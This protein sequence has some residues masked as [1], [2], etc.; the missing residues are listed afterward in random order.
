MPEARSVVSAAVVDAESAVVA[1]TADVGG[2][3]D[4]AAA[5]VGSLLAPAVVY[6]ECTVVNIAVA[7]TRAGIPPSLALHVVTF[8]HPSRR[9]SMHFVRAL[10]DVQQDRQ[11]KCIR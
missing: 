5:A 4:V 11:S 7:V 3:I 8:T 2:A 6:A 1:A 9:G 10:F